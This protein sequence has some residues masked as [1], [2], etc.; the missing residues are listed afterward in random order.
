MSTK[1]GLEAVGDEHQ[2]KH[3]DKPIPIHV[4][5]GVVRAKRSRNDSQVKDIHYPVAVEVRRFFRRGSQVNIPVDMPHEMLGVDQ[6]AGNGLNLVRKR[7]NLRF[8]ALVVD[9]P[10]VRK[11]TDVQSF[12]VVVEL[13]LRSPLV[14]RGRRPRSRTSIS[15][16]NYPTRIAHTRR[17][18]LD[19]LWSWRA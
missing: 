19:S 4:R 11:F 15:D 16:R 18:G 9:R 10:A 1:P 5:G 8:A 6:T 13:E 3:I 12:N 7:Y 14:D 17:N 2:I